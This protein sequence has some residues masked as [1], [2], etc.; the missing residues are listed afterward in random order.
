V[1]A[2]MAFAPGAEAASCVPP[3]GSNE[4]VVENC[5]EGTPPSLWQ[6][7]GSGDASIQGFAT[8]ISANQGEPVQFKIDTTA[9]AY[10]IDLY[11]LG[12]YGGD[13]ARK[14]ATIQPSQV[15]D[16]DPCA[17]DGSTGLVDCSDWS[18]SASW[19]VPPD[20]T[21]GIYLAHLVA[22]AG[23]QGE[24]HISFVVR[25]DAGR[26]DLLFQ[27]SD[28]TWQAYNTYGGSSL[29][30]G[31]PGPK[32]GAYKVSYNR[33]FTTASTS[34]EDWI[35]N[36]EFPM[37]RW[38]ERNG[39]DV[40]YFTGVDS[41]RLGAEIREHKA[42]LSVGHDEYW[43]GDQ[44]T[45]VEAAR[46]AGVNLAFFSGNEVFWK[47]RWEN[48]RRTLVSYKETHAGS[49]NDPTST[50]TGTWRDPRPF[51]PEGP[52][53]ENA[54]TGTA[55]LVNSGTRAIKVPAA[56]GK[57][58]FWRG[59]DAANLGAGAIE[60]LPTGTLGYEWDTDPDNGARPAGLVR[61]SS[62]TEP[63]VEILQDYGSNYASGT[64][65]HHLTLYRDTN[66]AGPDALILGA[67]TVQWSWGLD[68]THVGASAPPS[69]VM[70]QAT[71]NLFADMG[72]QP[73]TLQAGLQPASPSTDTIAP[74]ATI[75]SP[76][77]ISVTAGTPQTI[78]G[79]ATDTGGGVVGAVEVSVD[80]G[81][82]WHP[83]T[84]R[85]TWSYTWTP[86]SG[87]PVTP[88]ARAADDSANLTGAD[89]STPPPAGGDP[90]PGGGG[91]PPGGPAP[92]VGPGGGTGT[93][94][95]GTQPGA[96]GGGSGPATSPDVPVSPAVDVVTSSVRMS[97]NGTV[98]L[99]IACPR[100]ERDCR[101]VLRLRLNRRTIARRKF[102][103]DGGDA[104]HI[105][106]KL[107]R[108]TRRTLLRKRS[109]RVTALAAVAGGVTTRTTIRLLTPGQA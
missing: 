101:V 33:P 45:N 27:T 78:Q 62:T 49:S 93:P 84:G 35:F 99:R 64:A 17:T 11:R 9:S 98:R 65:T 40:S 81:A 7:P 67:G 25:D 41:D 21:S 37:I 83:A 91:T 103:V 86:V 52:K 38:L 72:V 1:L 59:T 4:I 6:I 102:T 14:V 28:T 53:P 22:E 79:T 12:W 71:T 94:G 74:S 56:E 96:P 51:N 68:D 80:A 70:Q 87:G 105:A 32:G 18:V 88:L 66:G 50:W 44:R 47:T 85:E 16:Q 107:N 60:T 77:T 34:G 69:P 57:L 82:T 109:L 15:R 30:S 10:R 90:P 13:G 2:G 42:F 26:S 108:T 104:R 3:P 36:S 20:A 92:P 73:A 63:N 39:F 75:T 29:Y 5:K 19:T 31:G 55:F 89:Q 100:G 76:A 61:L 23:A 58:R 8:D 95:T 97:R 43:S 54:L 48:N 106:L 24:S 46:D